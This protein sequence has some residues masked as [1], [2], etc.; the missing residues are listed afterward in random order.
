MAYLLAMI[1]AGMV[2]AAS[3]LDPLSRALLTDVA[4]TVVVFA[5]SIGFRNSSF[6]DVYWS[7]APPVLLLFTGV[8]I[9]MIERKLAEDKP[10]YPAY[11]DRTPK[12][13][14]LGMFR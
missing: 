12:L 1:V 11:R 3:T 6:Y 10:G 2:V 9:P 4:A 13:L 8:S 7:A 14:P 5:F